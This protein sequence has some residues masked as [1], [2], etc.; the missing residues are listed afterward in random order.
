MAIKDQL[1]R[2]YILI[3]IWLLV[4]NSDH[5]SLIDFFPSYASE[6]IFREFL[7]HFGTRIWVFPRFL[8][9][10]DFKTAFSPDS[11]P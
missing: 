10:V 11:I 8:K 9:N 1:A 7:A 2:G 4:L 5:G 6:V 3:G